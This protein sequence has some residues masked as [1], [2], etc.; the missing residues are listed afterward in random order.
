[1]PNNMTEE[2][3]NTI[4]FVYDGKCPICQIGAAYYRVRESVGRLHTVDARTEKDHPVMQEINRAGL[5]LDDGMVIKYKGKLYQGDDAL[6]LMAELGSDSDWFN[7]INNTLFKSRTL[8]A[9]CYPFMKG[10]RNLALTIK[11]A[12]RIRNLES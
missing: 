10:T 7:K 9:L 2:S 6:H 8:A 4:W 11:R 12:G 3:E 1:M 5:N